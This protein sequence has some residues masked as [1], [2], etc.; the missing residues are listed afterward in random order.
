MTSLDLNISV[1]KDTDPEPLTAELLVEDS[2]GAVTG[3]RDVLPLTFDSAT[4]G[5]SPNEAHSIE[6]FEHYVILSASDSTYQELNGMINLVIISDVIAEDK[7]AVLFP[8]SPPSESQKAVVTA[9][10]KAAQSQCRE[11]HF[12]PMISL[13]PPDSFAEWTFARQV[14]VDFP[15]GVILLFHTEP[16]YMRGIGVSSP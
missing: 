12:N 10:L 3:A 13:S 2:T 16:L 9:H 11:F 1:G 6:V 4:A 14:A 7:H 15:N 5:Q 8:A